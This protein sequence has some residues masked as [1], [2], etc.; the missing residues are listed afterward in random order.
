MMKMNEN[1]A[2]STKLDGV[3]SDHEKY[4]GK[5]CKDLNGH[6]SWAGGVVL[7]ATG[8][9]LLL[10]NLGAITFTRAWALLILI[11]VSAAFANALQDYKKNDRHFSAQ[12]ISS[13]IGGLILTVVSIVLLFNLPW[14]IFGPVMLLVVGVSILLRSVSGKH[15]DA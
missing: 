11:P 4:C 14:Q 5:N 1:T 13:L 3:G 7:I 15:H 10:Q 12:I 9:L 2:N 8:A 6:V